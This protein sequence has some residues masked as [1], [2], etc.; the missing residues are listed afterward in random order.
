MNRITFDAELQE[1]N[2]ALITL[3]GMA[4]HSIEDAVLALKKQDAVLAEVIINGDDAIDAQERLIERKCINI[5]GR[6]QPLAID[7]RT[8][9]AALK[10]ITDLERIADNATDIS[11]FVIAMAGEPYVKPLI[12][13]PLL[14]DISREMVKESL[15]AYTRRDRDLALAVIQRETEAEDIFKRIIQDLMALMQSNPQTIRQG[16]S[17][18]FIAK[19]LQRVCAHAVNVAEWAIYVVSGKHPHGKVM[20]PDAQ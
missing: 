4:E 1:L 5:I 18:L 3:G 10:V 16:V 2:Q 6:H 7:L 11:E 19:C 14:S 12:D 15:N 13:I 8:V 20:N 17:L 9:S